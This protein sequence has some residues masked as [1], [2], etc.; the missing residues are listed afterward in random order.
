MSGTDLAHAAAAYWL[1]M[2]CPVRT[3]RMRLPPTSPKTISS[4]HIRPTSLPA[5]Y[6]MSGT[7]LAYALH[8]MFKY[9]PQFQYNLSQKWGFFYLILPC[10]GGKRSQCFRRWT[11]TATK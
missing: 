8:C 6:A 5:S 2:R 11:K 3:Y 7:D 1:P 4:T 10:T 9:N